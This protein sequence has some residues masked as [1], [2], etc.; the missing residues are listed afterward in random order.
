MGGRGGAFEVSCAQTP[1]SADEVS[2]LAAEDRLL[3]VAFGQDVDLSAPSPEPCLLALC[4]DDGL[5]L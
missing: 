4:P 2:S 3:L 5:N 1:P